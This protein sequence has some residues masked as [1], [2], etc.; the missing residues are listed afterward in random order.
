MN[1]A[2]AAQALEPL[3]QFIERFKDVK[4]VMEFLRQ[5][6]AEIRRIESGKQ[7][8]EG[9][10]RAVEGQVREQQ[11][12]LTSLDDQVA[13]REDSKRRYDDEITELDSKTKE[14]RREF[15]LTKLELEGNA[16]TLHSQLDLEHAEQVQ[17]LQEEIKALEGQRDSLKS[18]LARIAMAA[19]AHV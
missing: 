5:G 15:D 16:R 14:L 6:D 1:T 12:L 18:D 19:G 2:E 10:L 3:A 17:A 7:E 9:R 4:E 11:A 13:G 8:A